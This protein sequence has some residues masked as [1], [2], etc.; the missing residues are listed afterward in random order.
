MSVTSVARHR[1]ASVAVGAPGTAAATR[2]FTNFTD[3]WCRAGAW[4]AAG[5]MSLSAV[6]LKCAVLAV[7][8]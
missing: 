5:E 2:A 6:G 1:C 8:L 7:G 4:S 3:L